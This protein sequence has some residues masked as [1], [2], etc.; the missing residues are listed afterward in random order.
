M[1]K[2]HLNSISFKHTVSVGSV[3][4]KTIKEEEEEEEEWKGYND[5]LYKDTVGTGYADFVK[6]VN[7]AAVA[8]ATKEKYVNKD[9]FK[10]GGEEL[11]K[12]I[13]DRDAMLSIRMQRD[14]QCGKSKTSSFQGRHSLQNGY[15]TKNILSSS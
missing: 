7:P 11:K 2:L 3:D 1:T 9:L 14:K 6:A 12:T 10:F 5:K 13:R 4:W 8:A 15:G